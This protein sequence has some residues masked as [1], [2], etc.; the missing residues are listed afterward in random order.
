M[1]ANVSTFNS[2]R[3][4]RECHCSH[5]LSTCLKPEDSAPMRRAGADIL[6]G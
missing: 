6:V 5:T 4:L 3:R 1:I 2:V